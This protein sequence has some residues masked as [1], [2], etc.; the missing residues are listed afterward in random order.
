MKK[1]EALK[2]GGVQRE[3]EKHLIS[4]KL[5]LFLAI[6]SLLHVICISKMNSRA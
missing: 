1:L 4:G 2:V 6:F 3:E 5:I